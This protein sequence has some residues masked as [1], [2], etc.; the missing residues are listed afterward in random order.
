MARKLKSDK[1]LFTATLLL[2]CTSVVMVYSS[3]ALIALE[4]HHD[5]YLF[6]AKQ[7]MWA[8]LGLLLVPIMMRIDYRTYRQPVFIWT[9]VGFVGVA[10][11]AVL[12]A[13]PVNG[14]SRWLGVGSLGIQP[15]EL[16]K[17]VVIMFVA[18]VLE[19]RMDQ[20]RDSP[21]VLLPIAGVLALL[22]GLILAEPDLGTAV[23]V[24]MIA[25]VM[26]FAAGIHYRYV[27]T[28]ILLSLPGCYLVIAMSPYRCEADHGF[29]GTRGTI[30]S[31][32][33][34]RWSSR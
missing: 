12:F 29:P 1:L 13:R 3:S 5:P 26:L 19:R 2:V 4:K 10:L 7:A 23:S 17:I 31:K 18:A 21:T 9:G 28:L 8:A 33:D 20:I 27:V 11:V 14:A 25:A 24:V 16:A 30:R 22:V 32:A 15:S 6:L 34:T